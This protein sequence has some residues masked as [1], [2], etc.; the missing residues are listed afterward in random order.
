MDSPESYTHEYKPV[1][2]DGKYNPDTE[3]ISDLERRWQG[4]PKGLDTPSF[5]VYRFGTT[6]GDYIA[7]IERQAGDDGKKLFA[8]AREKLNLN[9]KFE[10]ITIWEYIT[11]TSERDLEEEEMDYFKKNFSL[12][13]KIFTKRNT[14]RDTLTEMREG[15]PYGILFY[16][17]HYR[18]GGIWNFHQSQKSK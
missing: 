8:S 14:L 1:I 2:L 9:R 16:L 6:I 11:L 18:F 5:E 10:D 17:M 15:G 7:E 4:T 13:E 12:D 3:F